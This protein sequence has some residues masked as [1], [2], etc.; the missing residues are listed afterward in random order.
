MLKL[1][2]VVEYFTTEKCVK[3]L[4]CTKSYNADLVWDL[5]AAAISNISD[6]NLQDPLLSSS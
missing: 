2:F 3:S 6:S 5:Q 4:S 1:H